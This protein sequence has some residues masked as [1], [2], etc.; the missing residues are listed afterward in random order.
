MAQQS[1]PAKL[2]ELLAGFMMDT[3]RL[4]PLFHYMREQVEASNGKSAHVLGAD[5]TVLLEAPVETRERKVR[6]M[7][8]PLRELVLDHAHANGGHVWAGD[9]KALAQKLG[10]AKSSVSTVLHVLMRENYLKKGNEAGLYVLPTQK[11]TTHAKHT[12][13]HAKHMK[14]AKAKRPRQDRTPDGRSRVDVGRAFFA[15][16]VEPV[17]SAELGVELVRH[18]FYAG[19]SAIVVRALEKEGMI[20]QVKRGIW[21]STKQAA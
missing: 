17:P 5:Q 19:G 14:K 6:G 16:R 3:H 11:K 21:Q 13:T 20:K 9:A 10:F 2:F 15:T 7:G 4:T 8:K 12:T 1:T 18:G